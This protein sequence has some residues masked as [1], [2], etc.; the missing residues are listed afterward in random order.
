MYHDCITRLVITGLSR[1]M[2]VIE[3]L[4]AVIIIFII[5]TKIM[6]RRGNHFI[7]FS[8]C[9]VSLANKASST[10]LESRESND[11]NI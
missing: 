1:K 5:A 11:G 7:Q 2:S 9:S 3:I 8:K 10:P 4:T 6:L